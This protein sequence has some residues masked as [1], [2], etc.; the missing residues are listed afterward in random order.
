MAIIA[1]GQAAPVAMGY[2]RGWVEGLIGSNDGGKEQPIL[3]VVHGRE[4]G[5][6]A[7]FLML[8][9]REPLLFRSTENWGVVLVYH[10]TPFRHLHKRAGVLE[11]RERCSRTDPAGI[12][13]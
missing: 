5:C 10:G 2:K 4:A 3:V 13:T 7:E 12:A 11:C 9:P 1:T 8:M 6:A